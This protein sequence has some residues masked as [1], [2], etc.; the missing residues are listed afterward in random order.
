MQLAALG[1]SSAGAAP[2][3]EPIDWT[4][5]ATLHE[6]DDGGSDM[7]YDFRTVAKGSLGELVRRVAGLSSPERARLVIDSGGGTLNVCE[8]MALAQRED[9]P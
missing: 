9:L 7:H 6:R 4:A 8:I 5:P 1:Y 2:Y 3:M